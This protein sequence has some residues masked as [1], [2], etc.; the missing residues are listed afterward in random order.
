MEPN[1]QKRIPSRVLFMALVNLLFSAVMFGMAAVFL[2]MNPRR[3]MFNPRLVGSLAIIPAVLGFV[4]VWGLVTG[5]RFAWR[6][7]QK[8]WSQHNNFLQSPEAKRFF[9]IEDTD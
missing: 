1:Q 6:M 5:K 8:P 7:H 3:E 2:Q 4:A 9:G